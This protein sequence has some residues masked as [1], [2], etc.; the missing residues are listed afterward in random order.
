MSAETSDQLICLGVGQN[1]SPRE[2]TDISSVDKELHLQLQSDWLSYSYT[3]SHYSSPLNFPLS[4]LVK[5]DH[6]AQSRAG[7]ICQ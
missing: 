7:T 6:M 3:T 5:T 2:R 4:A 1:V